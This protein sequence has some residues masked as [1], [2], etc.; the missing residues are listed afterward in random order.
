[1]IV[2]E[3]VSEEIVAEMTMER[4]VLVVDDDPDIACYMSTLFEDHGYEVRTADS[5][6]AAL[7]ILE[8]FPADVLIVDVMLA[9]RS[10]LD[11]MVRL[12]QDPRY[13]NLPIIV[14][15]GNDEVLGDGGRSYMASHEGIRGADR[16]LGKPVEPEAL[17]SSIAQ[18]L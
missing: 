6:S 1:M 9:G 5:G 3:D 16:V 15:T 12:R 13:A 11:L 17:L 8:E 14:V 18:L 10:G 2:K 4:R 7:A